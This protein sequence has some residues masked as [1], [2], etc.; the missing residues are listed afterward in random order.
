MFRRR[1]SSGDH[2]TLV[3]R[4]PPP[5]I[6][7]LPPPYQRLLPDRMMR[8]PSRSSSKAHGPRAHGAEILFLS[9]PPSPPVV[10]QP[11]PTAKAQTD[12]RDPAETLRASTLQ[13][14]TRDRDWTMPMTGL[15][16]SRRRRR[17]LIVFFPRTHVVAHQKETSGDDREGTTGLR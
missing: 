5:S 3:L 8:D 1:Y 10:S 15:H 14:G 12:G 11:A 2:S 6:T 9:F 7:P 4:T 17:R 13:Q 16:R